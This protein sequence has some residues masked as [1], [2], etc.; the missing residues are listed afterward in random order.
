LN[1]SASFKLAF[2]LSRFYLVPSL[3]KPCDV[4]GLYLEF[5]CSIPGVPA[6]RITLLRLFRLSRVHDEDIDAAL[7]AYRSQQVTTVAYY[8]CDEPIPYRTSLIGRRPTLRQFKQLISKKKGTWRYSIML[9]YILFPE[10]VN[11]CNFVR[12]LYDFCV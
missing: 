5:T 2:T 11:L 7:S 6:D 10:T 3:Y 4:V 8:L 9:M 1:S 12:P